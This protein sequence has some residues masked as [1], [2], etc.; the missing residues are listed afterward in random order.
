MVWR[1]E[2]YAAKYS[3]VWKIPECLDLFYSEFTR[4]AHG[5][6]RIV[7]LGSEWN[8]FF[9]LDGSYQGFLTLAHFFGKPWDAC[10]GNPARRRKHI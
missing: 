3:V 6:F 4:G 8:A 5:L 2:R 9:F 10:Q 7:E 1:G